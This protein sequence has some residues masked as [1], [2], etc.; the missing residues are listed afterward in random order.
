ML[1]TSSASTLPGR[2]HTFRNGSLNEDTTVQAD[3]TVQLPIA[4]VQQPT[5][6]RL[7][8]VLDGHGR[9]PTD[10][11]RS[12][13]PTSA[14]QRFAALCSQALPEVIKTC[15][16]L[17]QAD[18]KDTR[19]R[20]TASEYL[21]RLDGELRTLKDQVND[22]MVARDA[23]LCQEAGATLAAA[24]YVGEPQADIDTLFC[25]NVGDACMVAAADDG[26]ILSIWNSEGAVRQVA[27]EHSSG[28]P[29]K[30]TQTDQSSDGIPIATASKRRRLESADVCSYEDTIFGY[31]KVLAEGQ[32]QELLQQDYETVKPFISQ[33]ERRAYSKK[34]PGPQVHSGDHV[35]T[36]P[37]SAY[38]LRMTNT[39]GNL[40]HAAALL[41]RTTV[42]RFDGV[43]QPA[44]AQRHCP[45]NTGTGWTVVAMSD[46]IKE[47][48]SAAEIASIA[49]SMA[50]FQK[51]DTSS[52]IAVEAL[53]SSI[54]KCERSAASQLDTYVHLLCL[55]AIACGSRDDVSCGSDICDRLR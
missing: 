1:P 41:K 7:I 48:F 53:D 13:Q 30:R 24:L 28:S 29:L 35:L 46:G 33:R 5:T 23:Q 2:K 43:S 38:C 20:Y 37:G 25:I 44:F 11:S 14:G 10:A 3:V 18:D 9:A 34:Q 49:A 32:T 27:R 19:Q 40:S 8:A 55:L 6:T 45:S 50:P 31:P 52:T 17:G 21:E 22:W 4:G 15:L 47:M 51:L 54:A 12:T 42:Y 26:S 36:C 16:L 39:L